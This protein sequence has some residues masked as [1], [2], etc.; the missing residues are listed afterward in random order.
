M[1]ETLPLLFSIQVG[2]PD[3]TTSQPQAFVGPSFPTG[4]SPERLP[5][6][7]PRLLHQSVFTPPPP[8]PSMAMACWSGGWLER[9]LISMVPLLLIQRRTSTQSIQM[10]K[11]LSLPSCCRLLSPPSHPYRATLCPGGPQALSLETAHLLQVP[12]LHPPMAAAHTPSMSA[13]LSPQEELL[14]SWWRWTRDSLGGLRRGPP[15]QWEDS[16]LSFS[17]ATSK[18][19]RVSKLEGE[20]QSQLMADVF[21]RLT[22]R[23]SKSLDLALKYCNY[24]FTSTFVMEAVLKLI[25]F[26]FRR[27]F[28]DRWNQLDLAIVLLSVMGI[29]LEEIEISAALPI[30]PTIIRIMRVLRIAR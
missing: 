27:F 29:T 1:E 17:Q 16:C 13:P 15:E 18:T 12:G 28:K 22:L 19:P 4:N 25:A 26:G 5:P 8:G 24:F 7:L 10:R 2:L 14:W 23:S 9:S 21:P 3:A 20:P 6:A 11:S 30:N